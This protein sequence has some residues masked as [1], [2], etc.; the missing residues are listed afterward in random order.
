ML[1]VMVGSG[2]SSSALSAADFESDTHQTRAFW[3]KRV[4]KVLAAFKRLAHLS[5]LSMFGRGMGIAAYGVSKLLFHA[6]F[7]ESPPQDLMVQLS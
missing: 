6:E 3:D 1:G 4:A 5:T 7:S 2:S